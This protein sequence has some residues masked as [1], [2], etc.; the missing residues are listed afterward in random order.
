MCALNSFPPSYEVTS[1]RPTRDNVCNLIQPHNDNDSKSHMTTRSEPLATRAAERSTPQKPDRF[2]SLKLHLYQHD[3]NEQQILL[4]T[5]F[6]MSVKVYTI[7]YVI[8]CLLSAIFA[9]V[10]YNIIIQKERLLSVLMNTLLLKCKNGCIVYNLLLFTSSENSGTEETPT[11]IPPRADS[12]LPSPRRAALIDYHAYLPRSC[13]IE[14]NFDR[15]IRCAH[16]ANVLY[17]YLLRQTPNKYFI[18]VHRPTSAQSFPVHQPV[19][20]HSYSAQHPS[21]TYSLH[22]N[23]PTSTNSFTVH[24]TPSTHFAH[25]S[26]CAHSLHVYQPRSVCPSSV[27]QMPSTHALTGHQT[28]PVQQSHIAS[29]DTPADA[30]NNSEKSSKGKNAT[31]SKSTKH[32][33]RN[34]SVVGRKPIRSR[35]SRI[36]SGDDDDYF[37]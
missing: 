6:N 5:L 9:A 4:S 19:F 2:N 17:H 29:E 18:P 12:N 3:I 1:F 37:I 21:S 31:P 27:H 36:L 35:L 13:D 34:S 8:S 30:E 33:G 28:T 11:K 25:K 10:L 15:H 32:V 22:L 14:L 26:K 24:M 20:A 7:R 16:Y 23:Q